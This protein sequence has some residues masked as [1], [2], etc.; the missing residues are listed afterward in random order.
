MV[1]NEY[2]LPVHHAL[3]LVWQQSSFL[4]KEVENMVKLET[5]GMMRKQMM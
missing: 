2:Y 4:F 5:G 1:G 3:T